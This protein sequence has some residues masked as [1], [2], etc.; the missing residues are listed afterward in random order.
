MNYTLQTLLTRPSMDS[1]KSTVTSTS[2]A[3]YRSKILPP[4]YLTILD[5]N[6]TIL[7]LSTV[8][9][10]LLHIVKILG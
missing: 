8:G 1:A 10:N 3:T 9:Q 6:I 5:P 7:P 4:E 2:R